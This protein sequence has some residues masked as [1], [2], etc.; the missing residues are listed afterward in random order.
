MASKEAIFH[1]RVAHASL[2]TPLRESDLVG[3]DESMTTQGA[4]GAASAG[5]EKRFFID[6]LTKDIELVPAI[7]DLVDNSVDGARAASSDGQLGD[8]VISLSLSPAAF[9]ITDNAGGI[10]IEIARNYAFRFG[11]AREYAGI[12]NSVGQFGVGMK[13]AIFKLGRLF[14]VES[15]H[16]PEL[17]GRGSHFSMEVDV[18]AWAES[19]EWTFEFSGADEDVEVKDLPPAGTRIRVSN[20]H[21]SVAQDL[22]D[23]ETLTRLKSQ[24]QLRHQESLQLGV[25]IVVNGDEPLRPTF[26]TLQYSDA[27]TPIFRTLIIPVDAKEVLVRLYA[28]TVATKPLAGDSA[29]SGELAAD[30]YRTPGDAGWYL[31]CNGRLLLAADKS[32]LT[33]WGNGAAL[34]HP[35]YSR[36]R[37]YVYL[38]S[39]DA[40]LLPWNTTKTA[41]DQ[42]S[43]V[44][45]TVQAQMISAL[46]E[47]QALTNRAKTAR[48]NMEPEDE[49]PAILGA[50]ALAP[51]VRL[52]DLPPADTIVAPAPPESRKRRS[53]PNDISRIQYVVERD[54]FLEVA[55]AL[56]L[57]NG[58]QVGRA[59]FDYFY[60]HEVE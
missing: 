43:P 46:S 28:G 7:L 9:E 53:P 15:T 14:E 48:D 50:L 27:L 52:S 31:F 40:S 38:E 41:V 34:F 51:N 39:P 36:F 33:G 54:R 12:P 6:M 18:N 8:Y 1:V 2:N 44:F 47:V 55:S 26:P 3:Q 5:A 49:Q 17:G 13:R 24:L 11:R 56:D 58:S 25:K 10:P 21:P 20:L 22:G 19:N 60:R 37:G 42:D 4:K 30:E 23:P 45:R 16:I 32:P 29:D 59:T 57:Q 35:Q